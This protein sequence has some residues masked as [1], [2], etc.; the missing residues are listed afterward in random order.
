MNLINLNNRE[1]DLQI[2]TLWTKERAVLHELLLALVEVEKRRGYL[3]MGYSGL[4]DYLVNEIKC[5]GGTAQRRIDAVRL[6]IELPVTSEKIKNGELSLNRINMI[7]Q[8]C[9]EVRK[10]R[11]ETVTANG[12]VLCGVH[13]R[14][15]Y[16]KESSIKFTSAGK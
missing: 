6:M 14:F 3:E 9:R 12:Q 11:Q 16:Q 10:I 1:L 5:D 7:Q 2:K 8:A 13:N 15:K 4:Y